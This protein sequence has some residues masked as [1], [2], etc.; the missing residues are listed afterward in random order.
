[1]YIVCLASSLSATPEA[2]FLVAS[3]L[4]RKFEDKRDDDVMEGRERERHA[5]QAKDGQWFGYYLA[6]LSFLLHRVHSKSD[7]QDI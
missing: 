4:R 2:T 5:V 3:G 1:M 7:A 6:R